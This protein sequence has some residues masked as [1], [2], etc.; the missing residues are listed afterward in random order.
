MNIRKDVESIIGRK[1]TGEEVQK[2]RFFWT[3]VFMNP[4]DLA[5]KIQK[6]G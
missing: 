3:R 5:E 6:G 1:L 4:Y 2:Y